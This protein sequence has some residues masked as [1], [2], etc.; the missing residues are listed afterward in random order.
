MTS[1]TLN[2]AALPPLNLLSADL[3]RQLQP[4]LELRRLRLGQPLQ[5]LQ[6]PHGLSQE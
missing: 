5:A 4:Q 1:G 2:R 6:R 3:L